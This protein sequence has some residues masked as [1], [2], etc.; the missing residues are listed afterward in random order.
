MEFSANTVTEAIFNSVDEDG[1]E[2][3]LFL[4]IIDHRN[5]S[6]ASSIEQAQLTSPDEQRNKVHPR[7]TT[8]HSMAG[9]L[10]LMA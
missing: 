7:F 5:N 1:M 10:N 3:V 4:D 9:W 2:N 8:M 6:E